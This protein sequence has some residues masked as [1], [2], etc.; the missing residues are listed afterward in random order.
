[1]SIDASS[2]EGPPQSGQQ[3]KVELEDQDGDVQVTISLTDFGIETA[4]NQLRKAYLAQF[5][6]QQSAGAN[7]AVN[8]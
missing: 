8:Y 5:E 7:G 3:L 6:Q 2:P 1:M 4:D